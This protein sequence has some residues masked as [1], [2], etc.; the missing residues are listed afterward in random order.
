MELAR[1][2]ATWSAEAA[3]PF[4]ASQISLARR[5][6]QWRLSAVESRSQVA[7]SKQS[8]TQLFI[9]FFTFDKDI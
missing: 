1:G 2:T 6:R 8:E 7:A 9:F 5:W 4:A 3:D